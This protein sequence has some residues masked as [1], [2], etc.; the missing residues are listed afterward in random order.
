GLAKRLRL[1][2]PPFIQVPLRRA[3]VELE[4]GRV[5]AVAGRCVAVTNQRHMTALGERGPGFLG[6]IGGH[7]RR[8]DERKGKKAERQSTDPAQH[9]RFDHGII[10]PIMTA[11]PDTRRDDRS[12]RTCRPSCPSRAPR[13]AP[14]SMARALCY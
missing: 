7:I 11:L 10:Q 12:S 14:P 4:A 5:T 13:L 2:A 1:F 8:D 6:I 3:V 9:A